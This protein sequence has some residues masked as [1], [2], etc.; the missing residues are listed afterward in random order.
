MGKGKRNRNQRANAS[1]G[2]ADHPVVYFGPAMTPWEAAWLWATVLDKLSSWSPQQGEFADFEVPASATR[3]FLA[4]AISIQ[5]RLERFITSDD[6]VPSPGV[7]SPLSVLNVGNMQLDPVIKPILDFIQPSG[8][9]P[10][11]PSE[12][13]YQPYRDVHDAIHAG[14]VTAGEVLADEQLSQEISRSADELTDQA[15]KGL[16]AVLKAITL[17][18]TDRAQDVTLGALGS[19][20]NDLLAAEVKATTLGTSSQ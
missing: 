10:H 12:R 8:D 19:F 1:P 3:V 2:G 18:T 20:M 11:H 13:G 4:R 17:T 6:L 9:R 16:S 14:L 5:A 15:G 7:L